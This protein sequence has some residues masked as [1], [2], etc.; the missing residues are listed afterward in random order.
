MLLRDE[1]C[2]GNRLN[3]N[4]GIDIFRDLPKSAPHLH[5]PCI[6]SYPFRFVGAAF[7][8]DES[9]LYDTKRLQPVEL[10]NCKISWDSRLLTG[11]TSLSLEDSLM[12]NSSII[13]VLH[14]LQQMPALIDLHLKDSIPDDSEDPSTYPVVDL[15]C[16]YFAFHLVL[17]H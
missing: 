8:I 5:T 15:P 14:A 2:Q 10:T 16:R 6:G 9:F 17:V 7:Q 11:L 4:S 13:Q 1:P 3:R 12:E